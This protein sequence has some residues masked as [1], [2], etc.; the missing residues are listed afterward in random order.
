MLTTPSCKQGEAMESPASAIGKWQFTF[1]APAL[2]SI[3]GSPLEMVLDFRSNFGIYYTN[4][5]GDTFLTGKWEKTDEKEIQFYI[6]W[7][8]DRIQNIQCRGKLTG[9]R[10][11]AGTEMKLLQ[12]SRPGKPLIGNSWEGYKL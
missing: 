2:F 3:L 6:T 4:E 5:L 7:T 9:K 1:Q 12:P 8:Y 11:M 10:V